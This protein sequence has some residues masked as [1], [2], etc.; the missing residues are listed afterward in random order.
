MRRNI[1][2]HDSIFHEKFISLP[3]PNDA[4]AI[5]YSRLGQYFSLIVYYDAICS[6]QILQTYNSLFHFNFINF[7]CTDITIF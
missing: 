4:D 3:G 1:R 6:L 5:F 2:P 7:S